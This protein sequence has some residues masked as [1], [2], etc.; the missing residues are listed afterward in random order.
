MR[1]V[2]L[3]VDPLLPHAEPVSLGDV[4][5]D[6]APRAG[7]LLDVTAQGFMTVRNV[8]H[9]LRTGSHVLRLYVVRG[10]IAEAGP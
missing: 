4:T 6:V 3:E 2:L 10:P 8:V 1:A 9:V 5:V 7:E